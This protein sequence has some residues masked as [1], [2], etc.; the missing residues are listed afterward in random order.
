MLLLL[1][2]DSK[3][4]HKSKDKENNFT[5]SNKVET[6]VLTSQQQQQ[7]QQTTIKIS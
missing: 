1:L 7:Q 3:D 6:N 5:D 2:Q 4:V